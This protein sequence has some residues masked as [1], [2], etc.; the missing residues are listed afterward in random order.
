[1]GYRS[2]RIFVAVPLRFWKGGGG[3]GDGVKY[4]DECEGINACCSNMVI[5]C[6]VLPRC[7]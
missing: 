2:I 1:M 4:Y 5:Q 3:G 6:G 7:L